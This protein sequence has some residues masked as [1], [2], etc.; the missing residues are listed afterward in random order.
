[1][2][3]TFI[4]SDKANLCRYLTNQ[5]D[6]VSWAMLS[7]VGVGILAVFNT[8]VLKFSDIQHVLSSYFMYASVLLGP[9]SWSS[10]R[11]VL[12]EEEM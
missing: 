1:M 12:C 7:L 3:I 4:V 11:Y 2:S 8:E 6:L 10:I 5:T 9:L